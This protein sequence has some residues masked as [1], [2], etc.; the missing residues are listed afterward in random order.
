MLDE[1]ASLPGGERERTV[2]EAGDAHAEFLELI[3][4]TPPGGERVRLM[5]DM[6][7]KTQRL[8][9]IYKLCCDENN[10]R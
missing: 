8:L 7:A 1:F 9:V 6:D 3:G 4:R 10:N 5:R 2:R